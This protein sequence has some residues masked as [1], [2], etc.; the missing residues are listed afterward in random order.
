MNKNYTR[1]KKAI[2]AGKYKVLDDNE[3]QFTIRYQLN[4][5]HIC[6]SAGDDHFVSIM[7]PIFADVTKD[8]FTDVVMRCH[9]LNGQLKQ[10]KLYL[11]N[12]III[13]AAEFYYQ[14]IKDLTYQIKVGLNN[15][16]S[17]KVSYLK[18]DK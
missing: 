3:E 5:I 16:I 18:Q 13:A 1:I 17:A 7:L 8:N 14:G 10:V 2:E 12:D 6:P 9:K 4:S 11:I 15:V